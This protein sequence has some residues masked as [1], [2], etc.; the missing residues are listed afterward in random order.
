MD[1]RERV[2]AVAK[3][4]P[5]P[6]AKKVWQQ[7]TMADFEPGTVLSFDQS[8]SNTGWCFFKV[9]GHSVLVMDKGTL[10]EA[11]PPGLTSHEAVIQRSVW[12]NNRISQVVQDW[13]S[14]PQIHIV[15]ER[16]VV[17]GKRIESSLLTCLG[18]WTAVVEHTAKARPAIVAND[19]MKAVLCPPDERSEKRYIRAALERLGLD[20]GPGWNEHNRDALGLGLVHLYDRKKAA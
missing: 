18:L 16:P 3:D 20:V 10:R 7:P 9:S 13:G 19:H 11:A 4:A 1:L 2:K 5:K 6:R 12:M 8:Y 14:H 15:G 17:A